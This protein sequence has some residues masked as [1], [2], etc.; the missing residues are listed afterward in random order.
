[1]YCMGRI[2]GEKEI[3]LSVWPQIFPIIKFAIL[4]ES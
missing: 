2:T 4:A 1:M 3:E